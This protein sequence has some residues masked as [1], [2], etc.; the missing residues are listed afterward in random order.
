MTREF[1]VTD[2][3]CQHCASS[4]TQEVSAVPG[5]R[6]VSVDLGTKRVRVDTDAHVPA[7][8][9]VAAINEAG[10]VDITPLS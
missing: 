5:V 9:I 2:M 7:E 3:S 6:N 8:Q 10:Y 1:T 4:I